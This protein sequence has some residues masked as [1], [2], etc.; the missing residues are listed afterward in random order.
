MQLLR[1]LNIFWLGA[2]GFLSLFCA[3]E[4]AAYH[5]S[6]TPKWLGGPMIY[7]AM[8]VGLALGLAVMAFLGIEE[9]HEAH[10]EGP[11][12]PVEPDAGA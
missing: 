4:I 12:Q 7:V 8:C 2:G 6:R 9:P 1:R 3:N 10:V 11:G 5:L